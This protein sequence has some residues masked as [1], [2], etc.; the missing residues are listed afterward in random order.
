M[1]LT[2]ADFEPVAK[3]LL[4]ARTLC[5]T[6]H[7]KSDGDGIGSELALLRAL[8]GLGKRVRVINDTVVPRGLQF[9]AEDGEILLYDPKRDETYIEEADTL[10][11][12]DVALTYRLGRMEEAFKRS[13]A[14]KICLDHH[15]ES[16][17][18]FDH[19]LSDITVGSTGELLFELLKV[20]GIP[21]DS[22][23]ARP[24]Y[25]SISVDTGS[26]A[27]ERCTPRTFRIASELVAAGAEPYQ[28][29]LNLNWQ[30]RLAEVK[31]EGDVIQRLRLDGS[32]EI[33]YSE[34][35]RD[36]LQRYGIDPME[37]PTVVN[38]PL[39]IGGVELA[40]L[41][42]ELEPCCVNVSARSKGKLQVNAL[43]RRFGGGGHPLAAGF[44]VQAPLDVAQARVLEAARELLGH[45]A[46][47][48]D[49][50]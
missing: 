23:V 3:A 41:F 45:P 42:V 39:S 20:A 48:C 26:F 17:P 40:L 31:L 13:R 21:L 47:L 15:T 14:V 5:L 44:C 9:L 19:L 8:R 22:D 46:R 10:V 2:K 12:L 7:V 27:Y 1:N 25:A 24:L 4:E 6:T 35:S 34:V 49:S 43:A 38:I 28:V 30:R 18:A 16:D 32:G 29:H 50:A 11:V 33:A 37:I 36:T